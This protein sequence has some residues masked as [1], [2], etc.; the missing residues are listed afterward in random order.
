VSKVLTGAVIKAIDKLDAIGEELKTFIVEMDEVIHM[1][2]I[3]LIAK[4]NLF[5]LGET[6]QAKSY[7][8]QNFNKRIIGSNY[9]EVLMSKLMDDERIFGKLDLPKFKEGKVE[10]I[11]KN[12]LPDSDIVFL[13]E[14]FKSNDIVLNTLLKSMNYEEID[15]EGNVFPPRHLTIFSASNELPNFKKEEDKILYPLYN[16]FHLKM[17]TENIKGKENYKKVMRAKLAG[18]DK[19]IKN[20]ITLEE[21]KMLCDVVGR[22]DVPENIIDLIWD[23]CKEIERKQ[24]RHVSNRKLT[25]PLRIL[26]ANALLAK[27]DKVIEKDLMVLEH[28]LWEFPEEIEP[29]REIIKRYCDNLLKEQ[30]L[31]IKAM[32]VEQL[33]AAYKDAESVDDIRK[34]NK[35]FTKTE[36]E[37]FRVHDM[38]E[39][40]QTEAKT[41]EDEKIVNEM[42][43]NF[44]GMYKKFNEKF[45]F[46]Y[47]TIAEMKRRQG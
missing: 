6:G 29:I 34:K 19:I 1:I 11:I 46:T 13:D 17:R 9:M 35:I 5:F 40:L 30:V 38:L 24:S 33:E 14:I 45:G 27:R 25:G 47:T 42:M 23:I 22:V 41:E 20:T 31:A 15:I 3:A 43:Q 2:K 16:R 18:L 7:T 10:I 21:L 4:Q 39:K 8:V 44:E 32:A 26:Q 12:K 37:F 28:Y 36:K